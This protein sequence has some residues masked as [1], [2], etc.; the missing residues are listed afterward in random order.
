[1]LSLD[2][3]ALFLEVVKAKGFGKAADNLGIAKSTLS[4][5]IA[6]LEHAIGLQLLNRTTRKIE[7]TEAGQWYYDK[8]RHIVE[9]AHLAHQTL[10][11]MLDQPSGVLRVSAPIEFAQI[12][13]AALIPAFCERY[14]AIKLDFFLAQH[15]VDM[16]AEPFDLTIRIGAQ[17]DSTLVSRLLAEVEGRVYAAP[18]YLQQHGTPQTP[19]DLQTHQCLIFRQG[20]Q[21]YWPLSDGTD[22]VQAPISGTIQSN[23]PGMNRELAIHGAGITLLP[24]LVARQ[25]VAQGQLQHI[26]PQW[27]GTVVPVYALTTTRLLPKKTQVFIDFLKAHLHDARQHNDPQT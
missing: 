12:F 15:K 9:E 14:P 7:L 6:R 25:A 22:E 5:R 1:M 27:R 4:V 8:A 2:D 24:E 10:G 26:L 23:S 13:I 18:S 19:D 16:I 21:D 11:D 20:F 3:M 17:A